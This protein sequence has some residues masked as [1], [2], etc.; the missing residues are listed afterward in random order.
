MKY[1]ILIILGLFST[2]L[3]ANI[4]PGQWQ[5]IAFDQREGSYT[6][7][8]K[9]LQQTMQAAKRLCQK[10]SSQRCKAAQSYCEQGH[11][12]ENRCL[13]TDNEG[14]A[15][16]T[17]GPGACETGIALCRKW[18]FLRGTAQRGNCTIKH[19]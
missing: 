3:L 14:H 5:C 8:G 13:V 9:S 6:A 11:F 1:S 2:S 17:T 4:S 18:Q 10:K 15:W 7:Y 19:P 12:V 16:N